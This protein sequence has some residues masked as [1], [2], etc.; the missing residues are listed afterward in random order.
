[1]ALKKG[2]R[3]YVAII[4]IPLGERGGVSVLGVLADRKKETLKA[5]LRAIPARLRR[6]IRGACTEDMHEGLGASH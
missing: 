1:M 2:H 5:F 6:T 3:D 4:T